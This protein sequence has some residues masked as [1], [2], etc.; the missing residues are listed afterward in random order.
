L[1][2]STYYISELLFNNHFFAPHFNRVHR[3]TIGQS[4]LAFILWSQA[5]ATKIGQS[6]QAIIAVNPGSMLASKMVREGFG[7]TDSDLH[8]NS[9]ILIRAS[10]S[11]AFI[12]TTENYFDNDSKNHATFG[13]AKHG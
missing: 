1:R 13:Y 7:V 10:L 5:L 11:D 8:I 3:Q 6:G 4:K 9:E 2:V 12:D